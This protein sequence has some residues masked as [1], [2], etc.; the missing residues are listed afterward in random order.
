MFNAIK[1]LLNFHKTINLVKQSNKDE[2]LILKEFPAFDFS[3]FS[4]HTMIDV[5]ICPA[6][7]NNNSIKLYIPERLLDFIELKMDNDFHIHFKPTEE[8]ANFIINS[9][10]RIEIPSHHLESI[11]N[12]SMGSLK[13]E[14]GVNIHQK[15]INKGSGDVSVD[16]FLGKSIENNSMGKIVIKNIDTDNLI[17]SSSG[18]GNLNIKNGRIDSLE[19]Y[20]KSMGKVSIN[21][22]IVSAKIYSTGSGD[23]K[24]S[25][26]FKSVDIELKSMGCITVDAPSSDNI[27]VL[28]TGSGKLSIQEI[29]TKN[30][31]IVLKSMGNVE[32]SGSSTDS[33]IKSTGSGTFKGKFQSE[34]AVVN[35]SSM[36]DI[37]LEV[38]QSLN[39]SI[40][41]MG[42]LTL[43]GEHTLNDAKVHLSSMGKVNAEDIKAYSLSLTGRSN[44]CNIK[45]IKSSY[46]P[47]F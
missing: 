7:E 3:N 40:A 42:S 23:T 5:V 36:G 30:S 11:Y 6:T 8:I 33:N 4:N 18:S 19:S 28:S 41:G 24:I 38:T 15:I 34:N 16:N 29:N 45:T 17:I 9:R 31:D 47:K 22:D 43:H 12:H 25:R 13:V 37:R 20:T 1:Q 21:A 14:Q 26:V 27:N 32:M 2:E 39:A 46:K 44:Q 35:M 10:P